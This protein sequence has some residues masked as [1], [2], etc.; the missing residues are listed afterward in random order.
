MSTKLLFA[1]T[2]LLLAAVLVVAVVVERG[3]NAPS[4]R[5]VAAADAALLVR[6]GSPS[7]GPNDAQ[8]TIV[9]F[10]DPACETCALFFPEVKRM[11][12]ANPGRLRL[13]TR[14]VPFHPGSEAVVAMLEAAQL[15]G[16]Y[17]E[18]LEALLRAQDRW[19]NNHRVQPDAATAVLANVPGLDM[20]RLQAD[21]QRPEVRQ[22]AAQDFADAKALRVVKT[23]EYFVN[24]KP[25][26]TFG[27]E[28][29]RGM[30]DAA[31][32]K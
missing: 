10:L 4:D 26:P 24:G 20:T 7:L 17:W 9:E 5:P 29:L 2:V 13:V 15:Q 11:L 28:E 1:I 19:V 32:R 25:L 30:V 23:P 27:L 14:H 16:K 18:A 3:G 12:A 21:V 8:V 31:L 6:P 22:R